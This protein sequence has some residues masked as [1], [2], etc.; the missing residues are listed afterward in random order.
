MLLGFSLGI[1]GIITPDATGPSSVCFGS[2]FIGRTAFWT[3]GPI[4]GVIFLA[5]LLVIGIPYL[6]ATVA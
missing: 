3:P 6:M 4:F 5:A 1:M 2:G